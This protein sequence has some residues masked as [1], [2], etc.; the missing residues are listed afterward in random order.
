[1][2]SD[3]LFIL[4]GVDEK[5]KGVPLTFLLFSAPGGNQKTC[6]GYNMEIIRKLLQKWKNS[7][8]ICGGESF[9]PYVA[10]NNTDLMERGALVLVFPRIWLLICKFHLHQCWKNHQCKV[11]KGKSL[12]QTDLKQRLFHLEDS[13]IATVSISKAR[14]LILSEMHV[15]IKKQSPLT[16]KAIEHLKYLDSYWTTDALWHCWSDYG[17][18]IASSL[19]KCPFEGVLPT[20]NHLESFNG[21][22]KCKH[23][24]Q[25]QNGGH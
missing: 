19:L 21:V 24:A 8:G 15:L 25:W 11:L 12:E 4:M 14:N 20:T 17:R 16:A 3:L 22:L 6:A 13:L 18:K 2:S 5:K 7:L 23:L 9:K 1:M 10:I